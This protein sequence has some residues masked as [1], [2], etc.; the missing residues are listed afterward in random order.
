MF[1][2]EAAIL[3]A[4]AA[5]AALQHAMNAG[6]VSAGRR[7]TDSSVDV[8]INILREMEAEKLIPLGLALPLKGPPPPGLVPI[9]AGAG[10]PR[11]LRM[12]GDQST[13]DGRIA[14]PRLA[15]MGASPPDTVH[16]A[17]FPTSG[18]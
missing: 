7:Y 16:D 11:P 14:A 13:I 4:A 15:G 18:P 8:L 9:A 5:L 3:R 10:P 2:D 6:S 1:N 12:C 17:G